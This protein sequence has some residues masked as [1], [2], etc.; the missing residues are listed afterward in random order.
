LSINQI[1]KE[2]NTQVCSGVG[3]D[4]AIFDSNWSGSRNNIALYLSREA[5]FRAESLIRIPGVINGL[6]TE[7]EEALV[8]AVGRGLNVL[9]GLHQAMRN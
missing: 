2:N 4:D 8:N 7:P 3:G 6:E 5:Y 1:V 9:A